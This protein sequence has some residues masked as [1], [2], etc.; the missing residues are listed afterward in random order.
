M[1]RTSLLTPE[2]LNCWLRLV[3][4]YSIVPLR[5][6]PLHGRI[7]TRMLLEVSLWH[8]SCQVDEYWPHPEKSDGGFWWVVWLQPKVQDWMMEQ[9]WQPS[10]RTDLESSRR[11]CQK[12]T[13]D[14]RIDTELWLKQIY[15]SR[16]IKKYIHAVPQWLMILLVQSAEWKGLSFVVYPL[17]FDWVTCLGLCFSPHFA[18]GT[19]WCWE[20]SVQPLS[21]PTWLRVSDWSLGCRRAKGLGETWSSHWS[22]SAICEPC[23]SM[24]HASWWL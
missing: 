11:A 19:I 15:V 20:W 2:W 1:S 5:N 21:R 16:K 12:S 14:K 17:P 22:F 7:F 10:I 24:A 23:Q 8:I 9:P 6:W 4:S 18:P 13:C 3:S